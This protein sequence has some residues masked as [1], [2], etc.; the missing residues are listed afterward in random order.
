MINR[1]VSGGTVVAATALLYVSLAAGPASAHAV[2][3]RT[4]PTD[5][6]TVASVPSQVVLTF[7][8]QVL[9]LGTAVEII[10]PDGDVATGPPRLVGATVSETIRAGAPAGSF[11]VRWRVTSDDGHPVSGS[12]T[13]R[14]SA[15]G[16]N[17]TATASAAPSRPRTTSQSGSA[18]L[19]ATVVALLASIVVAAVLTRRRSRSV[20]MRRAH[21]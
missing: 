9:P 21:D 14:A 4:S 13:F 15:A 11:T 12:F 16:G 18:L 19:V 1:L 10:G 20:Q 7:D 17:P 6:S 3:R 5:G 8:E 2:L